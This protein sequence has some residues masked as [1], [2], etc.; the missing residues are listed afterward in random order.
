MKKVVLLLIVTLL[1]LFSLISVIG[2]RQQK[3]ALTPVAP[4]PPA[5]PSP[6]PPKPEPRPA[7]FTLSGLT[8]I[9]G[10][11]TT[12]SSVTTEVLVTNIGELPGTYDVTL[13]ID[14][15]VEATEK[16]TL[17]GGTSQRV[18]FTTSKATAKIYAV[19]VGEL[20]GTFVVK[21]PPLPKPSPPPTLTVTWYQ[22]VN[23]VYGWSVTHPSTLQISSSNPAYVIIGGGSGNLAQIALN[24]IFGD[25]ASISLPNYVDNW[26]TLR[27]GFFKEQGQTMVVISRGLISLPNG[28]TAADVVTEI[29]SGV[30]SRL[31]FI[32]T[33]DQ[34]IVINAETYAKLWDII[35]PLFDRVINSFTV[36]K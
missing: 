30:K 26:L 5:V 36:K 3:S 18:T 21:A 14:D 9:P 24:S 19:T 15:M 31:I 10:E 25:Y 16:V 22:Y 6:P 23:P 33:G 27:E 13:K 20:S 11:V 2:C 32:L 1:L 35:S 34:A 4:G 28:V 7:T 29:G 8:I 17:N 12:G